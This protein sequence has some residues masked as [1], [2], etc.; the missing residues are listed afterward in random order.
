MEPQEVPQELI[1]ILDS[2]AGKVHSRSG[3]VVSCLAEIL[4]RFQEMSR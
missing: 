4:T 2:R 1:D 3:P